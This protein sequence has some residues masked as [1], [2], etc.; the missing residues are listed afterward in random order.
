MKNHFLVFCFIF[1]FGF[2]I[3]GQIN[4]TLS[5]NPE[6]NGICPLTPGT[7]YTINGIPDSCTFTL[8]YTGSATV[9][10]SGK[11]FTVTALDVPQNI[12]VKVKLS[13]K[14]GNTVKDFKIP[15]RSVRTEQ[16]K[17]TG[18]PGKLVAGKSHMFTIEAK[19]LYSFRG[20][21]DSAE[22]LSN[23]W[24]GGSTTGWSMTYPNGGSAGNSKTVN[25]VTDALRGSA[26]MATS[27][28][29]CNLFSDPATC[30]IS[31]FAAQP[32]VTAAQGFPG[33]LICGQNNTFVLM[34]SNPGLAGYNYIW[35][36]G[37]WT[38]LAS[39]G[40]AIV[41]PTTNET[42][43]ITVKSWILV[44]VGD[45]LFSDTTRFIVPVLPI[46]PA[47]KVIGDLFLCP[48]DQTVYKLDISQQ[49]S[50]VVTWA[51][52]PS[53]AAT[54]SSGTGESTP[55]IS[56]SGYSGKAMVIFTI[57]T[58]CGTVTRSLEIQVGKPKIQAVNV[59]GEPL[60]FGVTYVCPYDWGSHWIKYSSEGDTDNCIDNYVVSGAGSTWQGCNELDFNL[61]YNGALRPPYNCVFI[62]AFASNE[63]G[64]S[65]V[66]NIICPSYWACQENPWG[67]QVSPN[68]VNDQANISLVFKEGDKQTVVRMDKLDVLD[69]SG[70]LIHE[71]RPDHDEYW[72]NTINYPDGVY[73]V[74]TIVEGSPLMGQFIVEHGR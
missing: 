18:C 15:V 69:K 5:P 9:D 30:F 2:N 21:S 41:Q 68:P 52:S 13:A 17:L 60:G 22:V 35:D 58:P 56:T 33:F 26:I 65:S 27:R 20:T 7:T 72:L 54:P 12:V 61:Q 4:L 74:R 67:L 44:G 23:G 51:V 71:A 43:A 32:I 37:Q 38:G 47:T 16:P 28:S 1:C 59:D 73:F 11:T 53:N 55:P 19:H 57:Q 66:V 45:T 6:V 70:N 62:E 36:F 42:N 63:C 50:S 39:G 40:S 14:C 49:P 48:G 34:A 24:S 31:R 46:D 10:T 3:F 29:H 25:V 8:S 64:T